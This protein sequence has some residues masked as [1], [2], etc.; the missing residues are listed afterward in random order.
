MLNKASVSNGFFFKFLTRTLSILE[1]QYLVRTEQK[2]VS[3]KGKG[4]YYAL[5]VYL[6]KRQIR[7][8]LPPPPPYSPKSQMFPPCHT[9]KHI[10]ANT[11]KQT[12][13][14]CLFPL[15]FSN[16]WTI[17]GYTTRF[18]STRTCVVVVGILV[19][20]RSIKSMLSVAIKMR[21]TNN[22]FGC[23]FPFH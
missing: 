13:T 2:V 22:I 11:S 4:T 16:P 15:N 3:C 21:Q 5:H 6:N 20:Q 8:H 23:K 9:C 18:C 17:A 14:S 10:H 19:S 7:H 12:N 1:G